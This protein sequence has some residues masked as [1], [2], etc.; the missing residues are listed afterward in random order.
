MTSIGHSIAQKAA[1]RRLSLSHAQAAALADA[2]KGLLYR[3]PSGWRRQ[4]GG[5]HIPIV[6]EALEGRGLVQSY[7]TQA[8]RG[9]AMLT[10]KGLDVVDTLRS[11]GR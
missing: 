7:P 8:G 4:G 6:I 2:R 3:T 9:A 1:L 11:A 5:L 10:K